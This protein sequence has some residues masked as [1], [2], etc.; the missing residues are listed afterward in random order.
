MK[1]LLF[2]FQKGVSELPDNIF[3]GPYK[4]KTLI[5]ILISYHKT[6][7]LYMCGLT[8]QLIILGIN[9]NNYLV[10]YDYFIWKKSF[11]Y[12]HNSLQI[13]KAL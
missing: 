10:S 2:H 12:F 8:K 7:H 3:W 1:S 13:L 6:D 5:S 9:K 4:Q 11:K